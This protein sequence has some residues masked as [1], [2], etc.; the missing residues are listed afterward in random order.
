MKHPRQWAKARRP[1][2]FTDGSSECV[3]A[4]A[5]LDEKGIVY[6]HTHFENSH[7]H[8]ELPVVI[9]QV[10]WFGLDQIKE[11][12][13]SIKYAFP[14]SFFSDRSEKSDKARAMLE[15]GNMPFHEFREGEDWKIEI[16]PQDPIHTPSVFGPHGEFTGLKAIK[17]SISFVNRGKKEEY[18]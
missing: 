7:L 5:L 9:E 16:D 6:D 18:R 15:E 11:N 1:W 2:L 10:I 8:K 17:R 3:T 12:I 14:V 4:K 13:D